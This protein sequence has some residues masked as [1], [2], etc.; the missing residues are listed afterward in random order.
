MKQNVP[1]L[2]PMNQNVKNNIVAYKS[3]VWD[4][5]IGLGCNNIDNVAE[6]AFV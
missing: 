4:V 1:E 6:P 5:A 3:V 2:L